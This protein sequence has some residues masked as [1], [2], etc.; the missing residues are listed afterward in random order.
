MGRWVAAGHLL[1]EAVGGPLLGPADCFETQSQSEMQHQQRQ[2]WLPQQRD[3]ALL[4]TSAA[5]LTGDCLGGCWE[6]GWQCFGMAAGRK[7][8]W[9]LGLQKPEADAG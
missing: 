3:W 2:C 1:I 8:C 7:C 5:K 6:T 9:A 4:K